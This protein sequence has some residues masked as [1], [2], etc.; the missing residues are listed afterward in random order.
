MISETKEFK[1]E[2]FS[3]VLPI[4]FQQFMLNA[5]SAADAL[6]LGT[7]GQNELSAVSLAGQ[8]QFVFG[9]FLAAVTIGTSIFAAQY[10][11]KKDETAVEKIFG[12]ALRISLPISAV[13]TVCTALF[14]AAVMGIFTNEEHLI[15]RGANYLRTV[16]PSYLF[17]GISQIYLCIMKNCGRAKKSTVIS[18]VC[19]VFNIIMNGLLIFGLSVFPKMGIAG[20]ATATVLSRG[21]E[22]CWS[23]IAVT[24]AKRPRLR[25]SHIFHPDRRLHRDFWKYTLPVLGNELTWGVGFTMYSVIMGHLGSDAV[26]ANSVAGIAKNLVVCFC[27]GLGS[28]GGI[29]VGNLLGAGKLKTAKASGAKLCRMAVISG[30]ITGGVLLSAAPL[31]L[32]FT[33]LSAQ[34]HTY[35]LWMLVISAVYMV[36]KSV[37]TMTVAGIFCAGGDSKFGFLCDAVVM[38]CISVPL[39]L[40]AAFVL[41]LPVIV[42]YFIINAD[43]MLKLPAVWRHYKKYLWVKDL[44]KD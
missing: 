10:W 1:K 25:F 26:A 15:L 24:R 4:A 13:F 37:N 19:V 22:T 42:V 30:F 44:T 2:L 7:L 28:G 39:G 43:E 6:M 12:I 29:L 8:V 14:P 31:I 21:A 38:W 3:L 23:V 17:C 5:V 40:I 33:K 16:S 32:R 20:A 41:K 36:G 18:S 34:A 11:G 35:L 9:L 27:V